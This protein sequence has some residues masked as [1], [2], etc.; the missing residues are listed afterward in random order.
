MRLRVLNQ[1]ERRKVF[2]E[3]VSERS[4]LNY[5]GRKKLKDLCSFSTQVQ[6][7]V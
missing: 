6:E 3:G 4:K 1:K 5:Q 2:K 7:Y